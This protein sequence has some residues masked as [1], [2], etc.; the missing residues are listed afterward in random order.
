MSEVDGIFPTTV[1][2]KRKRGLGFRYSTKKALECSKLSKKIAK[3]RVSEFAS[4]KK[5]LMF[6][7]VLL[8]DIGVIDLRDCSRVVCGAGRLPARYVR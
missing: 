2:K 3:D 8:S 1:T 7:S 6:P 4:V 5:A